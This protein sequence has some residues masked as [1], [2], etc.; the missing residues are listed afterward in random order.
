M[1]T[2]KHSKPIEIL[3]LPN[4]PT[5]KVKIYFFFNYS[6]KLLNDITEH[7]IG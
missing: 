5:Y 4:L 7:I 1:S 6:L 2:C 3:K